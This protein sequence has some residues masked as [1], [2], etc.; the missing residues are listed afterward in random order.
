MQ[1]ATLEGVA[2]ERW[3]SE[4]FAVVYLGVL[5]FLSYPAAKGA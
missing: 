4:A 5:S 2:F 1:L 3:V